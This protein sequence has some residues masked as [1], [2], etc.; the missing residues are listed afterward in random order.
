MGVADLRAA[1]NSVA[2][3]AY[4]ATMAFLTTERS[5]GKEWSRLIFTGT[6]EGGGKFEAK[7]DLLPA[8]ADVIQGAKQ[9][10]QR[11]IGGD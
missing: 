4:N 5:G 8:S 2:S 6:R 9:T 11:L 7:S 1:F 10:A 3:P